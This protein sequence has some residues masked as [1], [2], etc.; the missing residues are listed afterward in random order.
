MSPTWFH[1]IEQEY[2]AGNLTAKWFLVL[3]QL[4]FYCGKRGEA[5][6]SHDTLAER[7]GCS[8][9]TVQRALQRARDLGLISWVERRVRSGW[10]WLRT[11]NVYRLLMPR[12]TT[13][14]KVRREERTKEKGAAKRDTAGLTEMLRAAM[15]LPSLAEIRQARERRLGLG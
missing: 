12:D 9:R 2:R 10:R 13:G 7:A 14:Q 11:S 8:T 3:R 5:W 4:G 15:R 6:P 1:R